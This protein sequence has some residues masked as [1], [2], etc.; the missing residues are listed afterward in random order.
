ME[1]AYQSHLARIRIDSRNGS[2]SYVLTKGVISVHDVLRHYTRRLK[3][4]VMQQ[5]C[6]LNVAVCNERYVE[7]KKTDII[8][9][10]NI[11]PTFV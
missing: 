11:S 8:Y 9:K 5:L 2:S 7:E 4:P 3:H 1:L 6:I 10:C